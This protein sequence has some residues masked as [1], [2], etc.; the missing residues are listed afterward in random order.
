MSHFRVVEDY[1]IY[2]EKNIYTVDLNM[3]YYSYTKIIFSIH[4]KIIFFSLTIVQ[5]A[6]LLVMTCN[7]LQRCTMKYESAVF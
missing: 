2:A 5:I 4:K 1:Q 3:N 7:N 6:Y